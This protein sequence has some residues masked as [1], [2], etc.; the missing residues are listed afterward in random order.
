MSELKDFLGAVL[1]VFFLVFLGF[2]WNGFSD[3][4]GSEV[5]GVQREKKRG[6]SEAGHFNGIK[7][8]DIDYSDLQIFSCR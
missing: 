8:K 6:L 2:F 7:R 3:Y 1:G 5:Q 4:F